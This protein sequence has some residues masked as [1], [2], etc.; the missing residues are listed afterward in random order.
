M[1]KKKTKPCTYTLMLI[2]HSGQGIKQIHVPNFMVKGLCVLAAGVLLTSIT[3]LL[4]YSNTIYRTQAEKTE[5][6]YLREINTVQ[7]SQIQQLAH[8]TMTL[9][10]EMQ[11][12][13]KLDNEVRK[14]V[15]MEPGDAIQVSRGSGNRSAVIDTDGSRGG[16]ENMYNI[17]QLTY[18]VEQIER[19]MAVRENSL[20][21][22]RDSIATKQAQAASTPSNW[23]A[24]GEITSAFGYRRSPWGWGR[25]FHEGVDIA[26]EWGTPISATADG[27]VTFS[28]WNGGYGIMVVIDHGNGIST[29]YAHNSSNKVAVGQHVKK[30]EYIADMGS[31]G[32]STG[33]HV[34]Y[35][36]R[37]GGERVNP[38]SYM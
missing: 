37:I 38:Q 31:T 26:S 28:G 14:M 3:M 7:V 35:E 23:P 32:A 30:G 18:T 6:Q 10:E 19:E 11:R 34:H 25:Q 8:T 12:V 9:Q 27:E 16:P 21:T 20:I 2:P 24:G 5:L 13:Q 4:H 29:A 22:L 17:Q 1:Q 15:G 33:P 36:V